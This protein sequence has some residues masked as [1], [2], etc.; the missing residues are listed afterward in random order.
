MNNYTKVTVEGRDL[1]YTI[2]SAKVDFKNLPVSFVE[3]LFNGELRVPIKYWGKIVDLPD[4][5]WIGYF[6]RES[7]EMETRI[8]TE[9]MN[10]KLENF[11][12]AYVTKTPETKPL[13]EGELTDDELLHIEGGRPRH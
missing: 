13:Q 1:W 3:V 8:T 12:E 2:E 7:A 4:E 5:I 11:A 10:E 6:D 9:Q